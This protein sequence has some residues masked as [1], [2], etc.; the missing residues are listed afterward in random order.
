[1]SNLHGHWDWAIDLWPAGRL[2]GGGCWLLPSSDDTTSHM[3]TFRLFSCTHCTLYTRLTNITGLSKK[4]SVFGYIYFFLHKY[5]CTFT[6]TFYPPPSP[7]FDILKLLLNIKVLCRL[8]HAV[9]N[10]ILG[11]IV[12]R[13]DQGTVRWD[14]ARM[15][16]RDV[17]VDM[18]ITRDMDSQSRYRRSMYQGKILDLIVNRVFI[19][20]LF[21]LSLRLIP[22]MFVNRIVCFC[23]VFVSEA[24]VPAD[25]F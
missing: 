18:V 13:I 24:L 3:D 6:R 25:C 4:T 8:S 7:I 21:F 1:M 16:T 11:C 5:I 23:E 22:R 14:G 17:W 10:A 19:N 20:G 2:P 15:R 9:L 12:S